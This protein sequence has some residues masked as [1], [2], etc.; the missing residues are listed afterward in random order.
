[1][2]PLAAITLS[3]VSLLGACANPPPPVR[4]GPLEVIYSCE[5]L[6][7][8]TVRPGVEAKAVFNSGAEFRL[9]QHP[10]MSG[11]RYTDGRHEFR[12]GGDIGIWIVPQRPPVTCR[13]MQ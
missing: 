6:T 13:R 3:L 8:V 9:S 5:D 10:S 2:R 7:T 1:M 11:F 12:G 4:P